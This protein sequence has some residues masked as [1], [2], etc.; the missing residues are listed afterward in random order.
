MV[1]KKCSRC[2][3][4]SYSLSAK[5]RWI[6]PSCGEDLTSEPL[7]VVDRST[8]GVLPVKGARTG[9]ADLN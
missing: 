8:A 3:N 2:D 6:C 4:V 9:P 7:W 5:G 1:R